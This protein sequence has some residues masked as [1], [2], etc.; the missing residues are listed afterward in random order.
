MACD[1][2]CLSCGIFWFVMV[3]IY[4]F[5]TICIMSFYFGNNID[6]FDRKTKKQKILTVFGLIF[7]PLWLLYY[8]CVKLFF[9]LVYAIRWI[10]NCDKI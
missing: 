1:G 9:C 6:E 10:F 3:L 2:H 5:L 4:V 7:W 8:L